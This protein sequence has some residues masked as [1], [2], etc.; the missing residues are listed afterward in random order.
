M[1]AMQATFSHIYRTNLWG[2]PESRSGRVAAF[3]GVR[4]VWPRSGLPDT[5]TRVCHQEPHRTSCSDW[6]MRRC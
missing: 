3:V 2:N 4:L 1:T 6:V 5:S